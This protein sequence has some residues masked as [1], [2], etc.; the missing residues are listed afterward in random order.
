MEVESVYSISAKSTTKKLLK[1]V[2]IH[3]TPRAIESDNGPPF[4][5][6]EFEKFMKEHGIKHHRVTPLHPQANGEAESFM[7]LLN[8]T[9]QIA[10]IT[11]E[12]SERAIQRC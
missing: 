5:S 12:D 10:N 2:A 3:G 11:G 7:R 6:S 8:K 4:S 1:I 9:E